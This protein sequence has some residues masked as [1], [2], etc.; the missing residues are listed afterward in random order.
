MFD[1]IICAPIQYP[2]SNGVL[3]LVAL[4][5]QI[6]ATG[7]KVSFCGVMSEAPQP[8]ILFTTRIRTLGDLGSWE[9]WK[10]M[11]EGVGRHYGIDV[12][13]EI[14]QQKLSRSIVL[15]PERILGNPLNAPFVVRYFGNKEGFLNGGLAINRS[16]S[17]FV[18]S[19]SRI[20]HP[21]PD[22]VLFFSAVN[23]LFRGQGGIPFSERTVNLTYV[24]K[25]HL[26]GG[27]CEI[28]NTRLITRDDPSTKEE[29]AELLG[30]SRFVFFF[31]SLTQLM[32]ETIVSGAIPVIVSYYP[33]REDEVDS[34]ETG[35]IPRASLQDIEASGGN[36][37]FKEPA[38][39]ERYLKQRDEY[40][41]RLDAAE[42]NY[43]KSAADFI[44][45]VEMHFS[46]SV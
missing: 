45:K 21:N 20:L 8:E 22:A 15:Y 40:L 3:S 24:G 7:R 36:I 30:K 19:H 41:Q 43:S 6:K 44:E 27:V 39:L 25:A 35:P 5:M 23:P 37:D 32:V 29:L 2:K 13:F 28:E 14:D 16:V 11:F 38:M 34:I 26:Y 10:S 17:D 31:D 12:I 33:Y 9:R 42:R 1:F 4:C 18:L 46:G